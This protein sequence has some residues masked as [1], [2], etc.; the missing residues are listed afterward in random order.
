[1]ATRFLNAL[2]TLGPSMVVGTIGALLSLVI[3]WVLG[4]YRSFLP[5]R[6]VV[7]WVARI[8]LPL[9]RCRSWPRRTAIIFV[10]NTGVSAALLGLGMW[11]WGG[12]VGVVL[13]GLNLG[14]ALRHLV[15]TTDD[16]ATP[17][18][19]APSKARRCTW[20]GVTLNLLE[21]PAIVVTLGLALGMRSV[22]LTVT[23]VWEVFA[24]GVVPALLIAAGGEALWMGADAVQFGSPEPGKE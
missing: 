1:M 8:I 22:P 10:N 6:L 20:I 4:R 19:T 5:V 16:L 18:T 13:L 2:A 3:G 24:I 14:I 7:W 12:R 15:T 17:A 21:I 11:R 9:L 23:Q